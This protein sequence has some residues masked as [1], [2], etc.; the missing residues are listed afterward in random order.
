MEAYAKQLKDIIGGLTGIL[1]A[2]IGLFVIVRV[3]FGTEAVAN[4][5]VIANISELVNVFVG[6][7]A[8]LAG[9]VTLIII[10]SVIGRK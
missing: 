7:G 4:F 6:D 3:V 5:D 10:L 9:L 8:S 1:V 2:T